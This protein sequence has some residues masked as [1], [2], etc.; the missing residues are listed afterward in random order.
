MKNYVAI[1]ELCR[2][3]EPAYNRLQENEEYCLL[4]NKSI[5]AGVE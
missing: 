3:A 5:T 4:E 1:G 2:T